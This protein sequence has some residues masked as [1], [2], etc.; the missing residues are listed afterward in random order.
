MKYY[1]YKIK[2]FG[3]D[4]PSYS[5]NNCIG[6]GEPCGEEFIRSFDSKTDAEDHIRWC[7]RGDYF[8]REVYNR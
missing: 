3:H 4:K 1:L 8:I 2:K 6:Y 7:G 5:E